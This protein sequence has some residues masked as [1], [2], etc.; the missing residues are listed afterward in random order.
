MNI[1]FITVTMSHYYNDEREIFYAKASENAG[2]DLTCETID[3][4]MRSYDQN[5]TKHCMS[6]LEI[7]N[8]NHKCASITKDTTVYEFNYIFLTTDYFNFGYVYG[9][10][11][12][13]PHLVA[14]TAN[15]TLLDHILSLMM[16]V[17][18]DEEMSAITT[19]ILY[20]VF[21][22]TPLS[23]NDIIQLFDV[24]TY[25]GAE[26]KSG[27]TPNDNSLYILAYQRQNNIPLIEYLL[28]NSISILEVSHLRKIHTYIHAIQCNVLKN[29][30]CNYSAD[31]DKLWSDLHL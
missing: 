29:E 3:Y 24:L 16:F 20:N 11:Y 27:D 1:K 22:S 28:K 12:D 13:I 21:R 26:F 23:N 10:L 4:I 5:I 30:S 6:K 8:L 9:D 17:F 18:D 14:Y 15:S 7:A 2:T 31:I 19:K 25:H